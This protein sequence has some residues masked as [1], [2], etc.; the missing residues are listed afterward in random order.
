MPSHL[1]DI[2]FD[3]SSEKDFEELAYKAFEKGDYLRTPAGI[4]IR[5]SVGEGAELW[6][7]VDGK[8]NII[9]LNPH[10]SGSS[11]MRAGLVNRILRTESPLD[12][13]FYAWASPNEGDPEDGYFPFV[14]DTPDYRMHDRVELP[15]I[16]DLQI[17]AFAHEVEAYESEDAYFASQSGDV[18]FA[19]ESFIPSGLFRPD[20]QST[21]PPQAHAIFS[22]HVLEAS[23]KTNPITS[24]QFWWSR[25]RTLGGEVDIVADP[26]IVI[27]DMAKGG[28]L[29]GLFW[30]SGR[31]IYGKEQSEV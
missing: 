6:L 28:V 5:W 12:G 9:G 15:R 13:A 22:G 25:V 30:L 26:L 29:R 14:F 17:A 24:S 19:S 21:T 3:L 31:L 8:E 16:F 11:R 7:Q 18:R 27:G 23:L 2:G 10:F 4:Y 1:S 20:G